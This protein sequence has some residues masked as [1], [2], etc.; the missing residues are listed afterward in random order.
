MRRCTAPTHSAC[1]LCFD[2]A[3]V[4][5]QKVANFVYFQWDSVA[6]VVQ[7]KIVSY[8]KALMQSVAAKD[9]DAI[10]MIK[11]GVANEVVVKALTEFSVNTGDTLV[12]DWNAFFG[13]LFVRFSD[14]FDASVTPRAAA[15]GAP[16]GAYTRGGTSTVSV[17]EPGYDAAWYARIAA[18]AGEKYHVPTAGDGSDAGDVG[19]REQLVDPR[20]STDRLRFM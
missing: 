9:A 14:G 4:R 19:A 17:K 20:L 10:A 13:E 7:E 16:T 2:D 11:N 5:I 15:P 8:E 3:C 1:T 6:P 12:D 18:D